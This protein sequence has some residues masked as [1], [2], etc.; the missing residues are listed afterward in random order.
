MKKT[1]FF[2]CILVFSL[3]ASTAFA[4]IT[5]TKYTSHNL[6][7][8]DK[9]ENKLSEEEVSRLTKRVEEIRNIDKSTLNFK[10]KREL[11]RELRGIHENLRRDG[12]V[13]YISGGTLLLIIILVILLA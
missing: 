3:S 6:A 1:M 5:D 10:E 7:I 11:R 13:I 12:G 9:K 2:I 4:T 8:T